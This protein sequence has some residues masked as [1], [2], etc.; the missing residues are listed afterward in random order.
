MSTQGRSRA[1]LTVQELLFEVPGAHVAQTGGPGAYAALALRGGELGQTT[2][3]LGEMPISGPDTGP[4]DLAMLPLDAFERL[5][6]YRGGAPAWLGAGAIGGVLRLVPREDTR[7]LLIASVTGGSFGS[8]RADATSVVRHGRFTVAANVGADGSR[9]DYPYLYDNATVFDPTDDEIRRRAN[10]DT[11]GAHGMVLARGLVGERGRLQLVL[12]GTSRQG[13]VPGLGASPAYQA[14]RADVRLLGSVEYLHCFDRGRL[15][16]VVGGG[17]HRQRFTDLLGEVGLGREATDDRFRN[18]FARVA[19]SAELSRAVELNL[20]GTTRFDHYAPENHVG[21]PESP[22][23]RNTTALTAELRLHGEL[24]GVGL[25]LRPSARV[26]HSRTVAH[27]DR[28]GQEQRLDA[29]FLRPT[30]RVGATVQPLAWLALVG[31]VATGTRLPSIL[32]LFGD[33]GA[34]VANPR[35][36]PERGRSLDGGVLVRTSGRHARLAAEARYFHLA[37]DDLIRYRA[38]SQYTAIAENVVSGT[39]HGVE[40]GWNLEA[41]G[42]VV[43]HGALTYLRARGPH[44]TELNWRPRVESQIGAE[45]RTGRVAFFRDLAL[46]TTWTHRAPFFHDPAN[47]V[48]MPGRHWLGLGAR[49]DLPRGFQLLFFARDLTDASGQDFLGQ[50]LPGRRYALTLRYEKELR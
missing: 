15:Q 32:E 25:E 1:D 45:L 50:P 26:E 3:V 10:A 40:A 46:V 41:F 6:V 43:L 48:R 42:H 16:L 12:F 44:D 38:T 27:A 33:R 39:V 19:G 14:R 11:L 17:T 5:E 35:L 9:G 21:R 34:L 28:H 4:F 13:G 7:D 22:S 2:T 20:I 8:W 36:E 47:L 49:A 23:H 37:I 24:R 18:G 29:D 30:F 31:S